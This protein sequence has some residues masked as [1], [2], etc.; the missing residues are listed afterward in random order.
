[1]ER[2]AHSDITQCVKS[3][4]FH[5]IIRIPGSSGSHLIKLCLLLG[6]CRGE[7]REDQDESTGDWLKLK[8]GVVPTSCHDLK[9][10][11]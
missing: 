4:S 8:L 6:R 2:K 9:I 11:P 5:A 7:T 3:R 10:F 1:M